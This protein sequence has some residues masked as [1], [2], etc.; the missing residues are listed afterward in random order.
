MNSP[1]QFVAQVVD[2]P[3]QFVCNNLGILVLLLALGEMLFT[4][5]FFARQEVKQIGEVEYQGKLF[6]L[7]QKPFYFSLQMPQ[8]MSLCFYF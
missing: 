5:V 8:Q 2:N 7:I 4:Y 3:L 1:L 6:S